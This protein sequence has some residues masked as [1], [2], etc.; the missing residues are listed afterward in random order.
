M[1]KVTINVT[2]KA[3]YL[4]EQSLS[5][6]RRFTWSYEIVIDNQSSETVQLLNRYWRISDM[7]GH[8]EEVRGP[9]VVGLQPVIKPGKQFAY[10]S[11]CQLVTPQGAME[12]NYEL[13]VIEDEE[14]FVVE[15]P[16]FIL[17]TPTSISIAGRS[18]LH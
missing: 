4:P 14:R 7:T 9:G 10:N 12:G 1:K 17:V 8:V 18:S 3:T 16:R 13:Q 5:E 11:F 2:A 15:I 6:I